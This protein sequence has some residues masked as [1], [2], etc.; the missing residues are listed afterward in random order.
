MTAFAR[1]V[2]MVIRTP[3]ALCPRFLN[4]V[5]LPVRQPE[6]HVH[7]LTLTVLLSLFLRESVCVVPADKEGITVDHA[8]TKES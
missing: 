5:V 7:P 1:F 3:L 6:L 2:L 8:R 4:L